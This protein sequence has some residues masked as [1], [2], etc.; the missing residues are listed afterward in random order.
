MSSAEIAQ[1][2]QIAAQAIGVDGNSI[3][4][5]WSLA[6]SMILIAMC[7][8]MVKKAADIAQSIAGGV[9]HAASAYAA[10]FS[11][12]AKAGETVAGVAGNA[13]AAVGARAAS[14]VGAGAVRAMAARPAGASLSLARAA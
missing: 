12:A 13:A 10:T 14:L 5:I 1:L 9:S 8:A 7:T 6:Q 2:G 3:A 11:A 4:M